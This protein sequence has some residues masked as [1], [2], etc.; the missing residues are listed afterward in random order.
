MMCVQAARERTAAAAQNTSAL[1]SKW[2]LTART[3]AGKAMENERVAN[4]ST[5]VHSGVQVLAN[6]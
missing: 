6:F 3:Q 5:S 2:G 4:V 1:L